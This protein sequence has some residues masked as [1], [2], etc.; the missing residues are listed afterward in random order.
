MMAEPIYYVG[1]SKG[2]V[3][4]SMV[5][6]ALLDY[7]QLNGKTPVLIE[8]DTANPDVLK[9]YE[10]DVI[11]EHMDLD[12]ANGWIDLLNYIDSH[13]E[14]A[15]VI[16]TP[17]RNNV[18]VQLY[19]HTLTAS[20]VELERPLEVLWVINRQRDSL[21]LLKEFME[22]MEGAH[23]HAVKNLHHG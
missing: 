22:A 1:G 19:G 21:E 10:K 15:I 6:S 2:G 11:N 20:I 4:K 12:N 3:G 23:I 17:A 9:Q 5:S 18:G 14:N 13:K 16:N 7:L 8:A